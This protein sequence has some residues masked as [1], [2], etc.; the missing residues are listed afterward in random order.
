MDYLGG[1]KRE[2]ERGE[3]EGCHGNGCV[4]RMTG[5]GGRPELVIEG[6][7]SEGGP[8]IVRTK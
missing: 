8:W 7:N 2:G 3:G 5:V 6:A 4:S 1:S